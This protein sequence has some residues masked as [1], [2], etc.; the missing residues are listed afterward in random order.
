MD[1]SAET[2]QFGAEH[3]QSTPLQD[4]DSKSRNLTINPS[5]RGI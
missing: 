2:S 3:R 4:P 1:V 5:Y